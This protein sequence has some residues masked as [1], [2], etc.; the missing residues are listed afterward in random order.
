MVERFH[1][2]EEVASSIL[3]SSTAGL[4]CF[5]ES[6]AWAG[7]VFGGLVAAEGCYHVATLPEVRADGSPRLRFVFT[8]QMAARDGA[9]LAGLR[10]FLGVGSLRRVEPARTGWQPTVVLTVNGRRSHRAATVPFSE[11][12]LPVESAKRRQFERWRTALAEHEVAHPNRWGAGPSECSADGCTRPV[13]GRG[14]CRR[15]YYRATGH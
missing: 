8:I 10:A 2:M 1:G 12:F 3:A 5:V 14:L 9:M 7:H 15:H 13:R 6:H 4:G 11:R